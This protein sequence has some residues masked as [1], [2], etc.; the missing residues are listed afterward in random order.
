MK[1]QA[2]SALLFLLIA[3]NEA[4]VWDKC[5]LGR[6][7]KSKGMDGFQGY[8]LANWICMAYHES[9]YDTSVVGPANT[10]G[11][12]DF[13]IFQINSRYWCQHGKLPS[14]NGCNKPCSSFLN[15]DISDDIECAKRIVQDPQKMDAWVAWVKNCKGKD[16]SEWTQGCSNL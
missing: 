3:T 4:K 10:D 9:K 12:L 8:S 16:L 11:S 6:E 13:G 5:E 14:A 2:L 15:D 7:M 1:I